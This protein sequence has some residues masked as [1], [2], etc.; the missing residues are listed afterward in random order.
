MNPRERALRGGYERELGE[1]RAANSGL[2]ELIADGRRWARR[3]EGERNQARYA[4]REL[5]IAVV[6][7][8]A[9]DMRTQR[10][11]RQAMLRDEVSRQIAERAA[12]G[13]YFER[14]PKCVPTKRLPRR[15]AKG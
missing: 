9:R 12:K 14:P 1:L 5:V 3:L 8:G 11:L 2:A 10:A 4:L 13:A 15:K 6:A 7:T